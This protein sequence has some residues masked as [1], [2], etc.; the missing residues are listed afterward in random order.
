MISTETLPNL[1]K[2]EV[3]IDIGTGTGFLAKHFSG[4]FERAIGTD[5]SEA[6]LKQAA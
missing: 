2:R 3:C 4:I 1:K 6:Q 5:L